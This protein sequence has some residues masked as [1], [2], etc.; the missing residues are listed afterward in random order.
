MA[1][2]N[3]PLT[4]RVMALG[5]STALLGF[6]TRPLTLAFAPLR[7]ANLPPKFATTALGTGTAHPKV[8]PLRVDVRSSPRS[9]ARIW[10]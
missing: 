3:A 10:S 7:F 9:C 6:A 5:F 1:L 8:G 4:L 2:L